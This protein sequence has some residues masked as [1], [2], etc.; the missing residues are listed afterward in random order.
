MPGQ[1]VYLDS[2]AIIKRYLSEEGTEAADSLFKEAENK[3]VVLCFSIW[4]IGEVI[5][6][7]DKNNRRSKN[8]L[9]ESISD[10][11]NELERLN[12]A[13][14]I[15]TVNITLPII[16]KAARVLLRYKL[17]IADALQIVSCK[18]ANCSRFFTADRRVHEAAIE[19]GLNSS[20]MLR[21]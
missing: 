3:N 8:K 1:I 10:F 16:F 21:S 12:R 14:S 9:S 19:E 20:L 2:S 13:G 5:G 18:E 4:N 17:Y 7:L 11:V 6:A 15:E